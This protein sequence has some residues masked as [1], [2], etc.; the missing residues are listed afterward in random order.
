MIC[1]WH[2]LSFT[3]H[4]LQKRMICVNALIIKKEKDYDTRTYT[5]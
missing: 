2:E 4:E 5:P 1:R 3:T